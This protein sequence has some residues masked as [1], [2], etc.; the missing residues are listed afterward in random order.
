MIIPKYLWT[1]E[2]SQKLL[3]MEKMHDFHYFGKKGT[4][5]K[6]FHIHGCTC[7]IDVNSKDIQTYVGDFKEEFR[8]RRRVVDF[9]IKGYFHSFFFVL[10][11]SSCVCKRGY[12][13]F[14]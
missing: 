5:K 8:E 1:V 13:F 6:S 14:F 4:L 12:L 7:C 11:D 3:Q 2:T 9:E 10:F